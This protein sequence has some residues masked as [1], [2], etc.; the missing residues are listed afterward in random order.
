MEE[1]ADVLLISGPTRIRSGNGLL[2]GY[3]YV[4]SAVKVPTGHSLS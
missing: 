2:A 3:V 4:A 1:I